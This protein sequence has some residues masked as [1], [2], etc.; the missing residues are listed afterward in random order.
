[1]LTDVQELM[2][3]LLL[4]EKGVQTETVEKDKKLTRKDI[5]KIVRF[6]IDKGN[7]KRYIKKI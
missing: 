3:N 5:N 2:L 6:D 7:A 1:M 4:A